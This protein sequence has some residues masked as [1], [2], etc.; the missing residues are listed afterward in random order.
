MFKQSTVRCFFIT[1]ATISSLAGCVNVGPDY[2]RPELD[3][4]ATATITD[5]TAITA[6]HT[7]WKTFQDPVLDALL[8]EAS[9][10]NQDLLIA[11]GRIEE[12]QANASIAYSNR[13]PSID[14]S[15]AASRR[16][17]SQ[18]IQGLQ[19]ATP[20]V[21]KDFQV[22]L[23]AAYEIDFWGRFRR[24]DEAARARLVQQQANRSVVF[25]TLYST[26]AQT[27]F[28]MRAYD[29]QVALSDSGL[30]TR[31]ENLRLQQKRF[32]AGSIS[33][34][35]LHQAEAEV[36]STE[37][38][39]AQ[40]QQL[41]AITEASLAI[42]VGRSPRNI[43]DP[44]IDRGAPIASLYTRLTPPMDLS[45]DLLNRRPDILAAEQA[46]IA[47]NA[48]IGQARSLLFPSIRLTSSVGYESNM[49]K[50]LI[51]PASMLW[52][53]GIG[54]TQPIFR[55]GAI[56]AV[57]TG[58]RARETQA[59]GQYVLSVQSAF[60]DVHDALTAMN[61]NTMIYDASKRR[62][63]ALQDALRLATLRYNNGYSSYL[64]VLTAQRDL[65]QT[66]STVIDAQRA[67][68]SAAVS[69]FRAVGGGW[70]RQL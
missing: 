37:I 30:Q 29:A 53:L 5:S 62:A 22:G 20:A 64:E 45:S 70:D 14:G 18:N 39:R 46:L 69:L 35:E 50:D 7:W 60:R 40:A 27:Y 41:V 63:T 15:A 3:L 49:L 61:A 19:A 8:E 51:N 17:I 11:A 43:A 2:Q 66:Q 38:S 9:V 65:L 44:V 21:T 56:G 47:A 16:G 57:V 28:G 55:A 67:H 48:D 33:R 26:I 54:L 6:L 31:Q 23:N 59:K 52:N 10:N 32:S 34:L 42:L 13:F 12:A 1:V 25:N 36:A 4:P 68:L 24:A 58:A